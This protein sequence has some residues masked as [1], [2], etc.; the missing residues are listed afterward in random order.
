MPA[1]VPNFE[2]GNLHNST[3]DPRRWWG[4]VKFAHDDELEGRDVTHWTT[5]KVRVIADES[6]TV[7]ELRE[8]LFQKAI[9][10][11][12]R[13]SKRTE[14]MTAERLLA[15]ARETLA[16]ERAMNRFL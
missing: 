13:A 7:R 1:G 8:L 11:L 9:E 6:A 5:V 16:D 15:S 12:N 10:E 3:E 4:E 14:G 2:I